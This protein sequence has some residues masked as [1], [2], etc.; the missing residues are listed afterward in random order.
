MT[1]E[2]L[3]KILSFDKLSRMSPSDLDS[4]NFGDYNFGGNILCEKKLNLITNRNTRFE[5]VSTTAGLI[6]PKNAFNNTQSIDKNMFQK[7]K[8]DKNLGSCK[9]QNNL[10]GLKHESHTLKEI[11]ENQAQTSSKNLQKQ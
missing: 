8:S 6:S 5:S 9:I 2:F 3:I 10:T 4:Y 7:Q 11:N 1:N